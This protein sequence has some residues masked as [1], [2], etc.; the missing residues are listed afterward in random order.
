MKTGPGKRHDAGTY[1]LIMHGKPTT[2]VGMLDVIHDCD[3]PEGEAHWYV[4]VP[5]KLFCGT[6]AYDALRRLPEAK[7][8]DLAFP[9]LTLRPT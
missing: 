6:V 2:R 7:R 1:I 4:F 8:P 3:L 9:D 5:G